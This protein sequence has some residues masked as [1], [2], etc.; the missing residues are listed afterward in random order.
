M[1]RPRAITPELA[2]E[3]ITA[4]VMR[5]LSP[6][7][8]RVRDEVVQRAAAAGRQTGGG[9]PVVLQEYVDDWFR[10]NGK[11]L[12]SQAQSAVPMTMLD[13]IK[14]A[15]EASLAQVS[16]TVA[17]REHALDSRQAELDAR[18]ANLLQREEKLTEREATLQQFIADLRADRDAERATAQA[19]TKE[20][21]KAQGELITLREFLD[22]L[23]KE[24]DELQEAHSNAR[25]AAAIAEAEA[26]NAKGRAAELAAAVEEGVKREQAGQAALAEAQRQ[27]NAARLEARTLAAEADERLLAARREAEEARNSRDAAQAEARTELAAA[28]SIVSTLQAELAQTRAQTSSMLREQIENVLHSARSTQTL[29]ESTHTGGAEAKALLAD[30]KSALVNGQEQLMQ[31]LR[32]APQRTGGP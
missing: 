4:V 9:S 17:E 29:V 1:S 6:T 22:A 23:A 19:V 2:N 5:G 3:A 11:L 27:L 14:E 21:A 16:A 32:E 13:Q 28:L 20:L 8:A 25:D 30:I 18:E 10:A 15:T 26:A 7:F 24:R 12:G 31:L